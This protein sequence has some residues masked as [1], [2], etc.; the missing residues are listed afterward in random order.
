MKS[1]KQAMAEPT[2]RRW[3][4]GSFHRNLKRSQR[5]TASQGATSGGPAQ[6][7]G[8]GR[9]YHWMRGIGSL[10]EDA[11]PM[12]QAA[13]RQTAHS[14][15][16]RMRKVHGMPTWRTSSWV[17]TLITAAPRLLPPKTT[18]MARPWCLRN[19][20]SGA[21]EHGYGAGPVSTGRGTWKSGHTKIV[22]LPPTPNRM[23]CVKKRAPRRS[24]TQLDRNS[25][26]PSRKAPA[27]AVLR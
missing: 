19:N 27:K 10:V 21:V 3:N 5:V 23:P 2:K 20:L 4:S 25:P 11:W 12:Q 6:S 17:A 7:Q 1:G 8:A 15:K 16:P 22:R 24:T 14:R 18:P 13:G 26:R 9:A